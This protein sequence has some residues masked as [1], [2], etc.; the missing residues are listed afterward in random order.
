MNRIVAKP[1]RQIVLMLFFVAMALVPGC[2]GC[3]WG[4][5]KPLTLEQRQELAEEEAKKKA[6]QEKTGFR[7]A[8]GRRF[9]QFHT[10]FCQTWPLDRNT[11]GVEGEQ[12]R[13]CRRSVLFDSDHKEPRSNA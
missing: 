9:A 11:P 1:A 10:V 5:P 2:G 3:Q 8:Q 13:L 4:K 7:A 6:A 12:F